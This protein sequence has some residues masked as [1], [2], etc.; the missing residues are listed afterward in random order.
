MRRLGR[1]LGVPGVVAIVLAAAVLVQ[2]PGAS[3]ADTARQDRQPPVEVVVGG[4]PSGGLSLITRA[5]SSGDGDAWSVKRFSKSELLGAALGLAWLAL[6]SGWFLVRPD[7]RGA[8]P[9]RR[10]S[11]AA[12]RAPPRFLVAI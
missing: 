4:A 10:A 11:R 8:S 2:G 1:C 5:R 6:L 7:R 9:S 12:P 3:G